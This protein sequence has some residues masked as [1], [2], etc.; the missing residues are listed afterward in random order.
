MGWWL[1][2]ADLSALGMGMGMDSTSILRKKITQH[3]LIYYLGGK[4]EVRVEEATSLN[5]TIWARW[6][7]LTV[8]V[9]KYWAAVHRI[10]RLAKSEHHDGGRSD[11][12]SLEV[13]SSPSQGTAV[14]TH[15]T[16]L[17]VLLCIDRMDSV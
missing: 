12:S 16:S 5:G 4:K 11:L 8:I 15:T 17:A 9:L 10:V 7:L 2:S 6:K 3:E 1:F 13:I 14:H